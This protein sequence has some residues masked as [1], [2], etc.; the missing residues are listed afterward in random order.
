MNNKSYIRE[1]VRK[2]KNR[3]Q[4]MIPKKSIEKRAFMTT[5][6]GSCILMLTLF[7]LGGM[8]V[9]H[10]NVFAGDKSG[11]RNHTVHNRLSAQPIQRVRT[12]SHM[13][14]RDGLEDRMESMESK[15]K[16]WVHRQWLMSLAINENANISTGIEHRCHSNPNVGFITFDE[17]WRMSKI[18]ETMN[19]TQEQRDL[20]RNGGR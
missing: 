7:T 10:G 18:P 16:L 8:V 1:E 15:V 5:F 3:R 9:K 12:E 11:G 19:L 4:F 2:L 17:A 13:S 20:I 6:L 14:Q